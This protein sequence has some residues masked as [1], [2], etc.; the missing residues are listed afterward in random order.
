MRVRDTGMLRSGCNAEHAT[1]AAPLWSLHPFLYCTPWLQGKIGHGCP[2]VEPGGRAKFGAG[3]CG[4]VQHAIA[5]AGQSSCRYRGQHVFLQRVPDCAGAAGCLLAELGDGEWNLPQLTALL[6]AT[7]SGFAEIEGYEIRLLRKKSPARIL[8]LNA[9]KLHY[10]GDDAVRLTLSITDVTNERLAE[11]TKEDLLRDKDVL[12]QELHHRVANSLQIIASVLLQNARKVHSDESR[13]HLVDAHQRVMS[14]AAL[15][16]QLAATQVGEVELRSY[17]NALCQSIGA[18]MIRDHDQLSLEVQV[19]GS[20]TTPNIS[21][22]LG[23]IVT[24]LVINALKHAFPDNRS[25]KIIV[26]YHSRGPNWTL[27][28]SDNGVGM[29]ADPGSAKAGLGTSIVK[30]LGQ[31]LGAQIDIADAKPGTK[32]SVV[33]KYVPV[34]VGYNLDSANQ[35]V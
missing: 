22:S 14:V 4:F 28:V 30:A 7:A 12:L 32:V 11:K 19:D 33:H 6:G 9:R 26:E 24:E 15:Q 27:S 2:R 13:V 16:Q 3:G 35:A 31:Q 21:V 5:A 8:I 1:H 25:G 29:P 20:L 10:D 17:F 34:L 23:L 18:S